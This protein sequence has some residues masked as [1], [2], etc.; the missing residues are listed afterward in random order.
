MSK[1][2][3]SEPRRSLKIRIF[4]AVSQGAYES[5]TS[6]ATTT[7]SDVMSWVGVAHNLAPKFDYDTGTTTGAHHIP[8]TEFVPL[9]EEYHRYIL[10]RNYERN[11]KLKRD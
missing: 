11:A 4:F 8:R 3:V 9:L 2:V 5:T 6:F 10:K 1:F 7:F